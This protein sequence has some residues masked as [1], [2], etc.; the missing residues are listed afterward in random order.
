MPTQKKFFVLYH[1]RRGMPGVA[2]CCLVV[3]K[4]PE[5]VAKLLQGQYTSFNSTIHDGRCRGT[6][7][8]PKELFQPATKLPDGSLLEAGLFLEYKCGSLHLFISKDEN[9]VKLSL[10]ELPIIGKCDM[11]DCD[12]IGTDVRVITLS[13]NKA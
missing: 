13:C 11:R 5:E 4:S 3:E 2:L 7:F 12:E 6:I 8:F 9:G 1:C 10:E